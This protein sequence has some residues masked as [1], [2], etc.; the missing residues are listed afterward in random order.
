MLQIDKNSSVIESE[1]IGSCDVD[2][3]YLIIHDLPLV[4][5]K[6]ED[7]KNISCFMAGGTYA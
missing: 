4:G 2:S 7:S 3:T 5:R 6:M 1:V